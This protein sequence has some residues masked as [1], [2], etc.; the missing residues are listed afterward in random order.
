MS[1]NQ[2]SKIISSGGFLVRLLGR[3]RKVGLS[4]MKNVLVS[5]AKMEPIQL[6]LTAAAVA[7]DAGIHKNFSVWE[8]QHLFQLKK[9]KDILKIVKSLEDSGLL[10]NGVTEMVLQKRADFFVWHCIY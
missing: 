1:R 5:L 4:L 7:A 2:L 8:Q 10:I 3:L 6:Q 9:S